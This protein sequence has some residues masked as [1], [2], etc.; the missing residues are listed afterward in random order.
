MPQTMP[1]PV[2]VT[3]PAPDPPRLTVNVARAPTAATNVATAVLPAFIV[4]EQ[5]AL[6]PLHAPDQ[7]VNV[8]LAPA[9]AVSVTMVFV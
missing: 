9:F 6:V 4:T 8:E 3:E 1:A 2:E 7:P 5:V